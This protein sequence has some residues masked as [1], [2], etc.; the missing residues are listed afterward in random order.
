MRFA[1]VDGE[2]TIAAPKS[3]GLCPLCKEQVI[4]KCGRIKIWHWAHK[5]KEDCDPWYE[6]ETE[7]HLRWKEEFPQEWQEVSIGNHRA[8]VKT[9][10]K[11][12]EFQNSSLSV[13]KIEEREQFYGNMV[14]VLNGET[15]CT[16]LHFYGSRHQNRIKFIWKWARKSWFYA[17]KPIYIDFGREILCVKKGFGGFSGLPISKE[18]FLKTIGMLG[19]VEW[20]K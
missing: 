13:D 8:D 10:L 4:P 9:P 12:I 11:V 2:R 17:K 15:I 20:Y 3:S 5:N 6:P 1:L 18:I 14:W 16:N 19:A 7:W